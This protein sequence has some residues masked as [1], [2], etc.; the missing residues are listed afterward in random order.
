MFF[1]NVIEARL[2]S[3]SWLPTAAEAF[4]IL[5]YD[6]PSHIPLVLTNRFARVRVRLSK[7]AR[8]LEQAIDASTCTCHSTVTWYA[9]ARP[10]TGSMRRDRSLSVLATVRALWKLA[11]RS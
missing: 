6:L 10:V 11:H 2:A 5:L 4:R 1:Q 3:R 8:H 9:S 7:H